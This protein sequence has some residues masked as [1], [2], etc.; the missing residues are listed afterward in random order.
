MVLLQE[1]QFKRE[2]AACLLEGKIVMVPYGFCLDLRNQVIKL[3]DVIYY[4]MLYF[5]LIFTISIWCT[6]CK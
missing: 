1:W 2:E 6:C 3:K 5:S 4:C